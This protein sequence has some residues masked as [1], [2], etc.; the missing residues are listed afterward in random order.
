VPGAHGSPK[1]SQS[2]ALGVLGLIA[3]LP[4]YAVDAALACQAGRHPATPATGEARM[5]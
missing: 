5:L 2:F 4:E 3:V 1:V